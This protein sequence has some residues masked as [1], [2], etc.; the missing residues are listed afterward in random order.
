MPRSIIGTSS[1]LTTVFRSFP[2]SF[3][4]DRDELLRL[5][6]EFQRCDLALIAGPSLLPI[7]SNWTTILAQHCCFSA[8]LRNAMELSLKYDGGAFGRTQISRRSDDTFAAAQRLGV[9][10]HCK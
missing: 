6:R 9:P 7:A 1:I 2:R 5:D 8:I 10:P 3:Q 4:T